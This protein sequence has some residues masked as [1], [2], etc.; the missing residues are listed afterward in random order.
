MHLPFLRQQFERPLHRAAADAK[1][2]R[3]GAFEQHRSGPQLSADNVARK[4]VADEL[5]VRARRQPSGF[6]RLD[7]SPKL[8]VQFDLAHATDSVA[9]SRAAKLSRPGR[10]SEQLMELIINLDFGPSTWQFGF[11]PSCAS[12][13]RHPPNAVHHRVKTLKMSTDC[14]TSS[15]MSSALSIWRK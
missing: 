13:R 3:D 10:D 2:R 9:N 7:G 11:P 4:V 6:V 8:V 1:K 5:V 12:P 14:S 15:Q